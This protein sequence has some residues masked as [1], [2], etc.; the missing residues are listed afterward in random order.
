MMSITTLFPR[1]WN[2]GTKTTLL[3]F[4][5]TGL[6][7]TVLITMISM[8]TATRLEQRAVDS[9]QGELAG[10]R[11]TI[12]IFNAATTADVTS[13]ARIL[14]AT[15][16]GQFSV[17]NN[18]K[19]M[20]A[21]SSTP[22]LKSGD[23]ILNMNL[24]LL[25]RFTAQTG[26]VATIFVADGNDFVR[27][28]TTLKKENG[29]RALGTK[30][31][32]AHGAYAA[33]NS[34][35][36]FVGMAK[37][38]GKKYLTEYSP[39]KD[40][41]GK[42]IGALFVG[43][44]LTSILSVLQEK[45]KHIKFGDSGYSYVLSVAPGKTYGNL[46]IHPTLNEDTNW[47]ALKDADGHEFIKDIMEKKE[48]SFHYR[49][50]AN[51]T[52]NSN[53]SSAVQEKI[54]IFSSIPKWNWVLV[55]VASIDEITKDAATIRNRALLFGFISL[56]IFA[57]LLFVFVQKIVT[58]PLAELEAVAWQI[59]E[60]DLRIT[61]AKQSD[62]EIGRLVDAINGIS[63]KLSTVVAQVRSGANTMAV[64]T[65]EIAA[66]N[67]DLSDRTERQ[68]SSLLETS[69]SMSQ[70]TTTVKQNADNA[71]QANQLAISASEVAV[72]GGSVVTQVIS[73]MGSINA[74]SKKVVDI[75]SVIDSIAFQ[76]NILALNAAVEA[77]RAGEQGRGFAVVA[78]EV[79]N[80]AQR[81]SAAAKEIK[82][83]INDSVGKIASG[84][85][86]VDQAGLTMQKIVV[87]IKNVTD[88][89]KEITAASQDQ[90][91]GIEQISHAITDMDEVT[92]QNAALVEQAAA[93]ASSLQEQA[94]N[95]SEIVKLFKI[96]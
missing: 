27:V 96:H 5:L 84:T 23:V 68:A 81:S 40:A 57:A 56:V 82:D 43:F 48:G 12:D 62:D 13:Y 67:L 22:Q 80:L 10:V 63:H 34:D 6:I 24:A 58:Q 14:A 74:S 15:V 30:L 41:G 60:G 78:S 83:L 31:D 85:Q 9:M 2:V 90:T 47:L 17:D 59:S 21:G 32:H 76:T 87:S 28:A 45:I 19:V 52:N 75:I 61:L 33:L 7:L 55:G 69:S 25:D 72:Q 49:E 86:L 94:I 8:M 88:I 93:A 1:H 42:V 16:E 65:T 46:V 91:S 73:T 92:Q 37:L 35:S 4:C 3:T 50:A 53:N 54:V 70:L 26:A 71:H 29:E 18:S 79:R 51:D 77:A 44:D 36:H 89:M 95:L 64:S 39:I 20:V 38:F 11:N 66:G